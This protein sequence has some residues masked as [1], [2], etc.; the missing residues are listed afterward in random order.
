MSK[1]ILAWRNTPHVNTENN[2]RSSIAISAMEECCV[3]KTLHGLPPKAYKRIGSHGMSQEWFS[4]DNDSE[5]FITLGTNT[6]RKAAQHF[7]SH[8]KGNV[9]TAPG[10]TWIMWIQ[11]GP[12]TAAHITELAF[13]S[14]A[15]H[16]RAEYSSCQFSL[17]SW[18][19]SPQTGGSGISFVTAIV[20]S[21][22]RHPGLSEGTD[23]FYRLL[24][25]RFWRSRLIKVPIRSIKR[26]FG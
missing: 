4:L 3:C 20:A 25:G 16:S 9:C 14:L 18:V 11:K 5:L 8:H 7:Q 1:P 24:A 10:L 26:G 23:P 22:S 13:A 17:V 19:H 15:P 21:P 6:A 2:S 12:G